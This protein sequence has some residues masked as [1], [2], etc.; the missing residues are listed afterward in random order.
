MIDL[1]LQ[2]IKKYGSEYTTVENIR[3]FKAYDVL[4]RTYDGFIKCE[5]FTNY[6]YRLKRS[7]YSIKYDGK[8][9]AV[10][11]LYDKGN[12]VYVGKTERENPYTRSQEH[13]KC[14]RK[15]KVY[16]TVKI[17]MIPNDVCVDTLESLFIIKLSP[18]YNDTWKGI[19]VARKRLKSIEKVRNQF[20]LKIN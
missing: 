13:L 18:K 9:Q 10:Y 1:E 20:N 11:F 17:M 12:L 15:P 14:R 16:D 19:P 7:A 3:R 2:Q 5:T 4:D 6:E 8:Q